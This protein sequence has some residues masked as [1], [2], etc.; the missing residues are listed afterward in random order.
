MRPGFGRRT[1]RVRRWGRQGFEDSPVQPSA[2][3]DGPSG[4]EVMM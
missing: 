2:A 4:P 3:G 1:S